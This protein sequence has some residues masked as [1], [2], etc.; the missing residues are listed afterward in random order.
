MDVA[1]LEA[2]FILIAKESKMKELDLLDTDL[3]S[4]EPHLLGLAINK[5]EKVNLS[6]SK[7]RG[8]QLNSL[9]QH[10]DFK[11]LVD[12]NFDYLDLSE[13]TEECLVKLLSL[14]QSLSLKKCLLSSDLVNAAL[15]ATTEQTQLKRANFHGNNFTSVSSEYLAALAVQLEH[16]DLSQTN[17]T[18]DNVTA[19]LAVLGTSE[20]RLRSLTLAGLSLSGV[21]PHLIRQVINKLERLDL[22]NCG[23]TPSQLNFILA[24][25][26]PQ[27]REISLF[28]VRME[29]LDKDVL[30]RANKKVF[31]NHRYHL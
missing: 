9:L 4:L 3:T 31:I 30:S 15:R 2:L 29:E 27:L 14:A 6:G 7:L 24:D 28:N 1:Q 19:V 16:L 10:F 11:S 8:D 23:L 18:E 20:C 26:G 21:A 25:L 5:L 22:S 17:M 12:V 13:I